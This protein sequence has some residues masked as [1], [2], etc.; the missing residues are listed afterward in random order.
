MDTGEAPQGKDYQDVQVQEHH[1]VLTGHVRLVPGP[2]HQVI[3]GLLFHHGRKIPV[4]EVDF[5]LLGA[6]LLHPSVQ[7]V[8]HGVTLGDA[9]PL[10]EEAVNHA[11]YHVLPEGPLTLQGPLPR[12]QTFLPPKYQVHLRVLQILS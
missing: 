11:Q 12:P 2:I 5:I 7:E 3:L 6:D 10:L 4:L 1:Q 8:L 9:I